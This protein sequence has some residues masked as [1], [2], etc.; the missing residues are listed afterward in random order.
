M[1]NILTKWIQPPWV[2][3]IAAFSAGLPCSYADGILLVFA[4]PA[5][6]S[7]AQHWLCSSCVNAS[8]L[9]A[10]VLHQSGI[11]NH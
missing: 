8:Q 2:Q 4:T 3:Q 5:Q 1:H 10:V 9:T 7:C 11:R 6:A